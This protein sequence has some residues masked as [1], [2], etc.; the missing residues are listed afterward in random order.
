MLYLVHIQASYLLINKWLL[1]KKTKT[2]RQIF[3][4][5]VSEILAKLFKIF[6]NNKCCLFQILNKVGLQAPWA[7]S[8]SRT[9]PTRW[10]RWEDEKSTSSFSMW[11]WASNLVL[12]Q[13]SKRSRRT[14]LLLV[15]LT[16]VYKVAGTLLFFPTP[17]LGPTFFPCP[18]FFPRFFFGDPD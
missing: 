5:S 8:L 10:W 7:S 14:C 11:L 4:C 16:R 18:C 13:E 1:S 6:R 9:K 3:K 15:I 2:T 17:I 12:L